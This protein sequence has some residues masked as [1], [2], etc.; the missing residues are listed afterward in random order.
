L[1]LCEI[2]KNATRPNAEIQKERIDQTDR[3]KYKILNQY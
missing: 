2:D 1:Q 3:L